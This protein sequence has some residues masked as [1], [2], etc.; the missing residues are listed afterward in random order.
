MND[1]KRINNFK[2]V[3]LLSIG[4]LCFY[5]ISSAFAQVLPNQTLALVDVQRVLRESASTISIRHEID[6]LRKKFQKRV[7]EQERKLRE[8]EQEFSRQRI[9][10]APDAFA[11]K[12][13]AFSADA[14]KVQATVRSR[15]RELDRAINATKNEILKNLI[16]VAKQVAK[17]R[18]VSVLIE[19]RFVFISQKSL[20]ITNEIISS[21]NARLPT[22]KIIFEKAGKGPQ[23]GTR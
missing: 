10:L 3:G 7:S 16:V 4:Y 20:D 5:G 14:R 11:K 9:L 8:A 18:K 21:L 19:K 17:T 12:R 2:W 6:K 22:V 13:R 15:K 1:T 23:K